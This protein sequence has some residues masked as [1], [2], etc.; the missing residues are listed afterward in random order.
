MCKNQEEYHLE[1]KI[2]KET[3]ECLIFMDGDLISDRVSLVLKAKFD[4][5]KSILKFESLLI[6]GPTPKE[7]LETFVGK[8]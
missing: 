8:A 1:I 3:S 6:A 7:I 5:V 4:P 2:K